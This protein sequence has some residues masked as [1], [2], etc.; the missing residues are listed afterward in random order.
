[1]AKKQK[2]SWLRR[3][4]KVLAGV[5]GFLVFII[6]IAK[7]LGGTDQKPSSSISS[8]TPTPDYP[9]KQVTVGNLSV[10]TF[11]YGQRNCHAWALHES[12]Y[13]QF[14]ADLWL[15]WEDAQPVFNQEFTAASVSLNIGPS[16]V[17]LTDQIGYEDFAQSL[18]DKLKPYLH[19]GNLLTIY[20]INGE[21]LLP[22]VIHT[23][24]V[25]DENGMTSNDAGERVDTFNAYI[26]EV[27]GSY[28]FQGYTIS[29]ITAWTPR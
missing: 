9:T 18:V 13:T 17:D 22:E 11:Q 16:D 28:I 10:K 27:V 3:N 5:A 20:V 15:E 2:P 8:V 1:V 24:Y 12:G 4:W 21:T 7:V 6:I 14:E 23:A 19:Q 29:S 26:G 25:L